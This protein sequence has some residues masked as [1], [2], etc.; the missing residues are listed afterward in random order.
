MAAKVLKSN[1]SDQADEFRREC[2]TL[3]RLRHLHIVQFYAHLQGDDDMV[4]PIICMSCTT[5]AS[6]MMPSAGLDSTCNKL[7]GVG[8]KNCC[9]L[10]GQQ[11]A[12]R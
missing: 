2:A 1:D 5:Y 11:L 3:E 9:C 12:A 4:G 10:N 7:T 8:E 6:C